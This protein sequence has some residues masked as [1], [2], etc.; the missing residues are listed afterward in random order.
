MKCRSEY[1]VK[2]RTKPCATCGK[3]FSP[4]Y[5]SLKFCSKEC[6]KAYMVKIMSGASNPHYKG[7]NVLRVKKQICGVSTRKQLIQQFGGDK[8]VICGW[9][10][11]RND[12]CHIVAA[13]QNGSYELD[14]LVLLCPNH[15]RLFDTGKIKR[16]DLLKVA[17]EKRLLHSE[18]FEISM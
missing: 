7:P 2:K 12:V 6:W 3:L 15:H 1:Y 18:T 4:P 14:N 11:T 16:E 9:S 13:K 5:P 8:C 10:Q 17:E